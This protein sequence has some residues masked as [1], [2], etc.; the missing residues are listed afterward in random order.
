MKKKFFSLTILLF[1]SIWFVFSTDNTTDNNIISDNNGQLVDQYISLD[2][3]DDLYY[4]VKLK[5]YKIK[6]EYLENMQWNRKIRFFID[7]FDEQNVLKNN[8][9]LPRFPY[10][11]AAYGG[12]SYNRGVDMGILYRMDN[13]NNTLLALTIA[14]SFGQRGKIWVHTNLE[15][16]GLLKDNRL[17]LFTTQSF[18]TTAAQYAIDDTTIGYLYG[19]WYKR[20][21]F[22][23]YSIFGVDYRI[24]FLNATTI[25]LIE[26]KYRYDDAIYHGNTETPLKENN[27]NINLQEEFDWAKLKQ[28]ATFPVGNDLSIKAKF[29]LPTYV[30]GNNNQFRFKSRITDKFSY[31]IF[32]EFGFK[33]RLIAAANYNISEDFSGDPY[34]RGLADFELTGWFALLANL[35]LY[36]PLINVNMRSAF[37][38]DL[39]KEAKFVMYYTIFVDGGFTIEKYDFLLDGFPERP[40]R[41]G[42]KNSLDVNNKFGQGYLGNDYYILPAITAGMGARIYSYFLHFILRFDAGVNILKAAIY[43]NP[44]ECFELVFSFSEMF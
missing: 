31:K 11:I 42:I 24:P 30:G 25:S 23:F 15:Y 17:K 13:I 5:H 27:F 40:S 16:P 28:T 39:K 32:R 22:G 41:D 9:I 43:Q 8:N 3:S 18:F 2:R 34:I 1:V 29:Y 35:E 12:Y 36:I 19:R 33:I 37:T 14:S 7:S 10:I 20:R 6:K 44:A 38:V 26:I 4:S 21:E